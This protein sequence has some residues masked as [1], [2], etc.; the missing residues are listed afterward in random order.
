[1]RH[2][3]FWDYVILNLILCENI[4]KFWILCVPK[5]TELSLLLASLFLDIFVKNDRD[6]NRKSTK[7]GVWCQIKVRIRSW[8]IFVQKNKT[9]LI[10][11][12]NCANYEYELILRWKIFSNLRID[13]FSLLSFDKW[14]PCFTLSHSNNIQ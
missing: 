12:S 2:C 8:L 13:R 1:M 7:T 11:I 5:L 6:Q 14:C 10:H 4:N 9:Y 3:S